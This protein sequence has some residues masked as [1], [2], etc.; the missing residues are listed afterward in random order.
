MDFQNVLLHN[1]YGEISKEVISPS[2]QRDINENHVMEIREHISQIYKEL[3]PILGVIDIVNLENKFYVIDGQHRLKALK[4]EYEENGKSIPFYVIYYNVDNYEDLE[5]IFKLRN[6]NMNIPDYIKD[7]DN[8]NR[9]LLKRIEKWLSG[10][11]VIF[12]NNIIRPNINLWK[13]MNNFSTSPLLNSIL[14]NTNSNKLDLFKD[15][16][17]KENTNIKR[18]SLT[19][20]WCKKNKVSHDQKM[21]KTCID[22]GIYLGLSVN[23]EW[24]NRPINSFKIFRIKNG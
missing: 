24:L 10:K 2:I 23:Q 17:E 1:N 16:F 9:E 22:C 4:D 8:P 14:E 19:T 11:S 20:N 12:N 13:F 15:I 3:Q 18:E 21:Y 7:R 6:R 5:E